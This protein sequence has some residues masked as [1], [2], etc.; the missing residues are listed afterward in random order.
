M[1]RAPI[2]P[3]V[4]EALVQSGVSSAAHGN[5]GALI[6]DLC[7]VTGKS[8]ATV[9]RHLKLAT[10]RPDRRQRSDAGSVSLT[11]DEAKLICAMVLEGMRKNGKRLYTIG[12]AVEVLRAN[13]AIRAERVDP[14]TGECSPLSD[15]AIAR[16]LRAYSLHPDQMLAP[17]PARE[18]RSLHPNHV[19]QIDASLCVLYYLETANPAETGLQVMEA[20]K[21]NKNKPRNLK[22]IE[23][24][25]VWSYEVTDHNSGALWAGYVND[26]ESAANIAES[27]IAAIQQRGDDPFHGVPLIL[28]MDM[29]S[30]NTSGLFK[31]LLKRLQVQPIPHAPENARATG[32]V[33]NAR[34]ILERGFE[35][36]L[37]LKPVH[38][39]ADL[40]ERVAQWVRWFNATRVHSRHGKTRAQQWLTIQPEQLRIAPPPEMC[41]A[42]LTHTPELR[43]VSDY[44]RIDFKGE[45]YDVHGLPGVMVGEKVAVTYSPYRQGEVLVVNVDAEGNESLHSAPLVQRGDDGFSLGE[46]SNIIGEDYRR[47]ADTLADAHRKELELLATEASSLEEAAAKRKAKVTPFGGRIDPDKHVEQATLPTFLPRHGTALEVSTRVPLAADAAVPTLGATAAMLRIVKGIGRPLSADENAFFRARF[48]AG[49]PEDQI[50]ALIE[51]FRNPQA[52][53]EAPAQHT[54]LRA[55]GGGA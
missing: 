11:R 25:R 17:A 30:A 27:F 41:R 48:A 38:S 37:R 4:N 9:Y 29:G 54:G 45:S 32:Q 26:G 39:L 36:G 34:N 47:H 53:P 52:A 14:A 51:Q 12:A 18:L 55:V 3:P 13:G 33:E 7:A 21:F 42:L 10:V 35:S 49:V 31:N 43:K 46:H 44:L 1:R 15:S 5:K 24:R 6:G 28:M 20:A 23:N 19:W 2:T 8:R 16:A 22:A 40:N 50:D